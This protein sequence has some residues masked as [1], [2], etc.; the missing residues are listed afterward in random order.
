MVYQQFVNYP[1]L[2]VY[3]NIA[4]PLRVAKVIGKAEIDAA[5][6]GGG[7]AFCGL[8]TLLQRLP[9]QL[10]GGQQQRTAIARALVKRADLVLLDEPLANLDY[11]LREELREELPRIFA[12]DRRDPRLRDDRADS[13]RCCSAAIP[14]D[15]LAGPRS[16][17]SARPP[18]SITRRDNI[19]AARVFSDPPLNE[20]RSSRQAA[21]S[22]SATAATL[23]AARRCSRPCRRRLHGSAF[24]PT[25]SS[26][27]RRPGRVLAFRR[28][29]SRHR[30]QRLRE[31]R[32]RRCRRSASSSA[33]SP[34][35]TSGSRASRSKSRVDATRVFVFDARPASPAPLD[36]ENGLRATMAASRSMASPTPTSGNPRSDA[37]YRAE[38]A[39]ITSGSRAAPTR[40][41]DRPAAA[42]PRSSTSF[43]V[44]S[45]PPRAGCCST[46]RTSPSCRPSSAISHRCS[47]FPSSTTR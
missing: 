7:D 17:N 45:F 40:C 36:R 42:R 4:S 35:C 10:S 28:R 1:S 20:S 18:K 46:T 31:L 29:Q 33:S 47:S 34:A 5:R 6:A 11:K 27:R 14:I 19:D 8:E 21:S 30:N 43:P 13:K 26:H 44:S 37:D 41:S 12:A 39:R 38:A 25:A 2:T 15:A 3:E 32:A 22:C 9:A 23:P 16:R 24:A